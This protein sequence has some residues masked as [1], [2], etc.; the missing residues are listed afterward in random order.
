LPL[1]NRWITDGTTCHVAVSDELA[2]QCGHFVGIGAH[3]PV[4]H[5]TLSTPGSLTSHDVIH[6]SPE[7]AATVETIA[8]GILS[9]TVH[10]PERISSD[11]G[12]VSELSELLKSTTASYGGPG[13]GQH[14]SFSDAYSIVFQLDGVQNW[15]GNLTRYYYLGAIGSL[16]CV[17]YS[18]GYSTSQRTCQR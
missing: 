13:S 2:R 17:L 16:N 4:D 18:G 15:V 9:K 5:V 10:N 1:R 6:Q 3:V 8:R 7:I 12:I 14:V 11:E